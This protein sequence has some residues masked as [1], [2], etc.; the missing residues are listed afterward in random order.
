MKKYTV[1]WPTRPEGVYTQVVRASDPTDAVR[2]ASEL[3]W[4]TAD[5]YSMAFDYEPEVWL[6]L[7]PFRL[8]SRHVAGPDFG[9]TAADAVAF[10]PEPLGTETV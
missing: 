9:S 7:R 8:R 1:T 4:P 5:G 3:D 2:V 6:L 10:V